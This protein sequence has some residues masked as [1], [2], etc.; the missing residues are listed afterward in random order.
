MGSV[1]PPAR[2][3]QQERRTGGC[4]PPTEHRAGDEPQPRLAGHIQGHRIHSRLR[5][6]DVAA[7]WR[8]PGALG[9]LGSECGGR[10]R[11]DRA[12]RHHSLSN[13]HGGSPPRAPLESVKAHLRP[14]GFVARTRSW[15]PNSRGLLSLRSYARHGPPLRLPRRVGGSCRAAGGAGVQHGA[16]DRRHTEPAGHRRPA[17]LQRRGRQG[18]CR[19]R[20]RRGRGKGR[21]RDGRR[22]KGQ[23]RWAGR[24]RKEGGRGRRDWRQRHRRRQWR[25]RPAHHGR[26]ERLVERA[27]SQRHDGREVPADQ[28]QHD[29]G[30]RRARR[31]R[32]RR[33]QRRR[34]RRGWRRPDGRRRRQGRARRRRQGVRQGRLRGRQGRRRRLRLDRRLRRHGREGWKGGQRRQRRGGADLGRLRGRRAPACLPGGRRAAGQRRAARR[35]RRRGQGGTGRRRRRGRQGRAGR[36]ARSEPG[37]GGRRSRRR[38]GRRSEQ[39]PSLRC[40]QGGRRGRRWREGGPER[41]GGRQRQEGQRRQGRQA[42]R[43]RRGGRGGRGGRGHVRGGR[44]VVGEALLDR[45]D[46]VLGAPSCYR[47]LCADDYRPSCAD[48]A[49]RDATRRCDAAAA[50]PSAIMRPALFGARRTIAHAQLTTSPPRQSPSHLSPLTSHLSPLTSHLSPLTRCGRP[51]RRRWASSS[52]ARGWS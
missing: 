7:F 35:R 43:R 16:Q 28:S 27:H 48:A 52:R 32:R 36:R 47:P 2:S 26:D 42:G 24:Q 5:S 6:R 41:R 11:I 51:R 33:R 49:R 44:R 39:H 50:A 13:L 9:S 46:L 37:R 40:G 29:R 1:P 25:R 14:S 38:S 21:D 45:R 4:A 18:R 22:W 17:R 20:R 3:P 19:R 34:R 23:G 31:R 15:P 10:A 30:G 8:G 12:L